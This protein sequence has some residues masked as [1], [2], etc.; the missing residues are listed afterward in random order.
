MNQ[1]PLLERR[2]PLG[3][4][5]ALLIL[6]AFFFFLPSGFRAARLS[7]NQKENDVKDWLPSDFPETAE[8]EWFADHFAGESFVLAT[9]PGCVSGDQRLSLLEQK[10]L[11]ESETFDPSADLTL[12]LAES[13]QRAKSVGN[14]LQLLLAGSDFYDWGGQ[15][16]KWLST[17][18]GQWYYI[19]PKGHLYRWDE[20]NNGPAALIRQVKKSLGTY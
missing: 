18:S 9:W 6:V 3:I 12:E 2:S 15:Q 5:Y 7:L 19:T 8:L 16:E 17:P 10:L 14:E 11:H 4:S 20:P 1:R 13:Y